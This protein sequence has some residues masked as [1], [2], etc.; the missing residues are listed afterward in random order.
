MPDF[1]VTKGGRLSF[2]YPTFYNDARKRQ[3][4]RAVSFFRRSSSLGVRPDFPP[5]V[6]LRPSYFRMVVLKCFYRQFWDGGRTTSSCATQ[7]GPPASDTSIS[8]L[9]PFYEISLWEPSP[10]QLDKDSTFFPPSRVV[11]KL[12]GLAGA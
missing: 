4:Y 3:I 2:T 7:A 6:F 12:P 10:R 1:P 9:Y 5:S 8:L 11:G